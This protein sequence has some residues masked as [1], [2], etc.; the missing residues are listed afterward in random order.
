LSNSYGEILR[1]PGGSVSQTIV[2]RYKEIV[3]NIGKTVMVLSKYS[4]ERNN[5]G[6][7]SS[8]FLKQ[9]TGTPDFFVAEY[10]GLKHYRYG[11]SW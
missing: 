11:T 8:M 7:I 4:L 3:G 10:C 6:N 5:A 9:N 1:P 2:F